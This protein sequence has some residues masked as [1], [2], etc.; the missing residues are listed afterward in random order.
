MRK[1]GRGKVQ[2]DKREREGDLEKG[3]ME[4]KIKGWQYNKNKEVKGVKIPEL[5]KEGMGREQVDESGQVQIGEQN[6]GGML[7]GGGGGEKEV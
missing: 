4:V 5:F 3:D 7:L 2:R 1:R 6:K